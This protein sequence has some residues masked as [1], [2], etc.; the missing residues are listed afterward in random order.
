MQSLRGE[1]LRAQKA[2]DLLLRDHPSSDYEKFV[3]AQKTRA[4]A[5]RLIGAID[6]ST[7]R[8]FE[9]AGRGISGEHRKVE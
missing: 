4:I 2:M 1:I 7:A 5:N 6:E 8:L 3:F 9:R